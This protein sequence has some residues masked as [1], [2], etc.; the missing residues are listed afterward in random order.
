[1]KVSDLC[2]PAM[3]YFFVSLF[4]LGISAFQSFNIMSLLIKAFFI[5]FWTWV[6]NLLCNN[7]LKIVSWILILLPFL[8]YFLNP[9]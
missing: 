2:T 4:S 7:G 3:L 9:F 6:L 5:F 8:V 1:M